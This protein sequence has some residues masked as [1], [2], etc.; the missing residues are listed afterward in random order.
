MNEILKLTKVLQQQ[1]HM[2]SS[3]SHAED[4]VGDPD[5]VKTKV[6]HEEKMARRI[7]NALVVKKL[8]SHVSHVY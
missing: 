4:D 3:D 1:R 2:H 8:V 6:L 5:V 7:E